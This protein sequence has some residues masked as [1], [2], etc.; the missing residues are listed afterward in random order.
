M[1]TAF[2]CNSITLRSSRSL[3][4]TDKGEL[5]PS[6]QARK[7]QTCFLHLCMQLDLWVEI[8][9]TFLIWTGAI[10]R[11]LAILGT[12]GLC[13]AHLASKFSSPSRIAQQISVQWT[14]SRYGFETK[15][16]YHFLRYGNVT[17]TRSGWAPR[18][19]RDNRRHGTCWKLRSYHASKKWL[20]PQ[21]LII[22]DHD[23]LTSSIIT[24]TK[25][26][27]TF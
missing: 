9:H 23:K 21:A 15:K 1:T 25:V 5:E 27:H 2:P 10:G 7:A 19:S 17:P 16:S 20:S 3:R 22:I 24:C 4:A 13:V 14:S 12:H 26:H 8:S 11:E 6:T 18:W